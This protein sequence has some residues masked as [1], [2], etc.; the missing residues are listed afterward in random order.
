MP[1]A[2]LQLFRD[3]RKFDNMDVFTNANLGEVFSVK[4]FFVFKRDLTYDW[5][6]AMTHFKD[7]AIMCFPVN[8]RTLP[9]T[10]TDYFVKKN[11]MEEMKL[12]SVFDLNFTARSV[13]FKSWARQVRTYKGKVAD[14]I[15]AVRMFASSDAIPLFRLMCEKAFWKMPRT[16][17]ELYANANGTKYNKE[18]DDF[19]VLFDVYRGGMKC[20]ESKVMEILTPRLTQA[21]LDEQFASHLEGIE[22]AVEVLE[23]A[24]IHLCDQE[25]ILHSERQ[26]VWLSKTNTVQSDKS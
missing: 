7:S 19:A 11:G 14:M 20:N 18:D 12:M 15:P 16:V 8:V 3:F 25:K 2:D 5:F 13:V 9:G 26:N 10:K 23:E 21:E 6:F 1:T 22:E 4:H 24:D 17:V